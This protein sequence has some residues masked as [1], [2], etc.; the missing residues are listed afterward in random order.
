M[1]TVQRAALDLFERH[2]FD[3][4]KVEEVSAAS[5]VSPS[6]IYRHF[7]TKEQIVTWDESDAAIAK[8]LGRHLG[9]MPPL[10]ALRRSFMEA[11]AS[12]D[13][14]EMELQR[15]R[16]ALIDTTPQLFAATAMSLESGREEI[17]SALQRAYGRKCHK[18]VA[19]MTARIGLQALIAGF[20]L[21]QRGGA[22]E[23]L[24][25]CIGRAF[26]AASRAAR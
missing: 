5:G 3:A 23:S 15:R 17:Q 14:E 20:E 11:Y 19:E 4:V 16:G 2:G 21:W 10:P 8:S 13:E 24:S 6:T 1:R 9:R 12:H 22:D 25:K 18:L 7:G 26:D